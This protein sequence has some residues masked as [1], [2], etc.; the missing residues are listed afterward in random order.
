MLLNLKII[1]KVIKAPSN[2]YNDN[3]AVFAVEFNELL[4]N[5]EEMKKMEQAKVVMEAVTYMVVEVKATVVEVMEHG[6]GDGNGGGDTNGRG[7]G[8]R[9]DGGGNGG[10]GCSG[11]GSRWLMGL[12]W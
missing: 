2:G 7:E 8:H 12:W 1:K 11:D 10:H 6:G 4:Q 9:G 3:R 5:L